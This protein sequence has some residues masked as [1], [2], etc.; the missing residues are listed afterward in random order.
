[1]YSLFKSFSPSYCQCHAL[2]STQTK[3]DFVL[4][5]M[6]ELREAKMF[7][8]VA[9]GHYCKKG[10]WW[11]EIFAVGFA[12]RLAVHMHTEQLQALLTCFSFFYIVLYKCVPG[13]ILICFVTHDKCCL[14]WHNPG[15]SSLCQLAFDAN[16]WIN[17]SLNI[18]WGTSAG[19]NRIF[20]SVE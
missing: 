14:T 7:A 8:M 12:P 5:H 19:K 17:G 16:D 11:A 9:S 6:L 3:E 10:E 20:N 13:C 4:L 18:D 1:M 15:S 2:C